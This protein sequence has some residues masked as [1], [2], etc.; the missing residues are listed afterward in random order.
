[1][2]GAK[3]F[4][5]FSGAKSLF[6]L[7]FAS[8]YAYK[9]YP[10]VLD[11]A[12]IMSKPGITPDAGM[13]RRPSTRKISMRSAVHHIAGQEQP[14]PVHQFS[15]RVFVERANH[16]PFADVPINKISHPED[17]DYLAP[18]YAAGGSGLLQIE[19]DLL[20]WQYAVAG[21]RRATDVFDPLGQLAWELITDR[22]DSASSHQVRCDVRGLKA[23]TLYTVSWHAAPGVL[24]WVHMSLQ[25]SGHSPTPSV[26]YDLSGAGALGTVSAEASNAIITALANGWKRISFEYTTNTDINNRLALR[27]A[28]GNNVDTYAPAGF[29]SVYMAKPQFEEGSLTDYRVD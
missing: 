26:Y 15:N 27:L 19:S 7:T 14:Y 6:F 20:G 8:F 17:F 11:G 21:P 12:S 3:I 1:M 5:I 29:Q 13:R 9:R 10:S 2:P 18:F 25:S 24:D 28:T 4:V 16:N 22:Q 23:N